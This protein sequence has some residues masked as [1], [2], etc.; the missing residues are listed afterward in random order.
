MRHLLRPDR[1]RD[2][3]AAS[4]ATL[5]LAAMTARRARQ[6]VIRNEGPP[7]LLL[8]LG[9]RRG[10]AMVIRELVRQGYTV[11]VASQD[12][13]ANE[14][15][16]ATAWHKVNC[17]TEP[18]KLLRIARTIGPIA[19]LVE[20]RNVLL[21]PKAMLIDQLGLR[22]FGLKSAETSNSKIAFREAI[23]VAGVTNLP[24]CLLDD[25]AKHQIAFPFLV[26]PE[27]GTGSRGV[28]LV[29]N[30]TE[31]VAARQRI[32][33][34]A[35][36]PDALTGGR[37]LVEGF[38]KGRQFDVEG[39]CYDGAFYPL[40][41][42]EE[43]YEQLGHAFPSAWYLFNPPVPEV[44]REQICDTAI[45][46]VDACGVRNGAFHCEVRLSGDGKVYPIDYSNRLGYPRAVSQACGLSYIELYARTMTGRGFKPPVPQRHCVFQRFIRTA[47]EKARFVRLA[48]EVPGSVLEFR[49]VNNII[50]GEERFGRITL[51]AESQGALRHLLV[52]Y[53]V[54]PEEWQRLYSDTYAT[55][56]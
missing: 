27:L 32:A 35:A 23:D 37:T 30:E 10:S 24:W 49:R 18:D 28:S 36:M 41:M 47:E 53:Q 15:R 25:I 12:F 46:I 21:R 19:V 9:W 31:L 51:F 3:K 22:D 43:H 11:H 38:I 20:Q 8:S 4:F 13:P 55:A 17:L 26:K 6:L 48:Q 33:H 7:V 39:V 44:L 29:T 1:L 52:R 40:V 14:A 42:V 45:R 5:G 34:F 2:L 50:A 54:E 56:A 16:F